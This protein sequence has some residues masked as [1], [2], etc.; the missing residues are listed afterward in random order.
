MRLSA[1]RNKGTPGQSGRSTLSRNNRVE[2][3]RKALTRYFLAGEAV[4]ER[5]WKM[6]NP[7]LGNKSPAQ[8]VNAGKIRTVERYVNNLG[9][10][11]PSVKRKIDERPLENNFLFF[12]GTP[13]ELRERLKD[14][15]AAYTG[16]AILFKDAESY[17]T[18]APIFRRIAAMLPEILR[19]NELREQLLYAR[20]VHSFTVNVPVVTPKVMRRR[21]GL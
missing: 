13:E 17:Y 19:R 15:P 3:L 11:A 7:S 1:D 16:V 21:S 12:E 5:F 14:V 20:L 10:T 8:L 4:T 6:A 18:Q 9:K 2:V